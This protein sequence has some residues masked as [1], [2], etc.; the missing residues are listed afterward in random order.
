MNTYR[1]KATLR[2]GNSLTYTLHARS[3]RRAVAFTR[4]WHSVVILRIA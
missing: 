3:I 1:V 2:N 4:H